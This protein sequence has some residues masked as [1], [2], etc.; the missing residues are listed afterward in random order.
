MIAQLEIQIQ[1]KEDEIAALREKGEQRLVRS[2]Q[3]M[4]TNQFLDFLMGRRILLHCCAGFR[5]LT[6]L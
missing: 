1:Q 2:Q 6:I 4:H 5:A 3:T